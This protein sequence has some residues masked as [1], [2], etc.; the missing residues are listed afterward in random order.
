MENI[1]AREAILLHF[2]IL[3]DHLSEKIILNLDKKFRRRSNI[4]KIS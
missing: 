4:K 1:K 3:I 2:V